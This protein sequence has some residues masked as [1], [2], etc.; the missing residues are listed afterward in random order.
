MKKD[1][2]TI[3]SDDAPPIPSVQEARIALVNAVIQYGLDSAQT[4]MNVL[5]GG[6]D[7][8]DRIDALI[9]AVSA[10]HAA[11]IQRLEGLVLRSEANYTAAMTKVEQAD[12]T[13][14][15]QAQEIARL[16][17]RLANAEAVLPNG[18]LQARAEAAESALAWMQETLRNL[19]VPE[20]ER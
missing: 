1:M 20:P 5:V 8:Q 12:A 14:Q 6:K 13:I 16:E 15:Q 19:P 10:S 2:M 11:T 3:P 4:E 17:Q 9:A 7:V 18:Q